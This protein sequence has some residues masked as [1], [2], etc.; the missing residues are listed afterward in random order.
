MSRIVSLGIALFVMLSSP[1][2]AASDHSGDIG[3]GSSDPSGW[4]IAAGV[5]VYRGGYR[6]S[7]SR[8]TW[9]Q[10]DAPSGLD[11]YD[12]D[13]PIEKVVSG[14]RYR[15]YQR[16]GNGV[17]TLVW[18]PE[19][20]AQQLGFD[21]RAYL[22]RI[23]PAPDVGTAPPPGDGIV[24]VGMWFWTTTA[25]E[26]LRV[27]AQV[28]GPQGTVWSTTTA[29][30]VRLAVD[31]ADASGST[32]F[33][34]EG[35]GHRWAPGLGDEVASDCS[36]TYRHSSVLAPDGTAF[37]AVVSIE[38]EV[39]WT[40]SSGAGGTLDPITTTTRVPITVREIQAIVTSP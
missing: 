23:L 4:T 20:T 6:R 1:A 3:T 12:G 24:T 34:C 2:L 30:P 32:P 29:T 10:M 13:R 7:S 15:L 36:Y 5:Q 35:P 40:S 33:V 17:T 19:R 38:W 31:P 22:A 37:P 14:V 8:Y 11:R 18:V 27:T 16:S 25:W 28:P 39:S 21:G 26:P 9:R